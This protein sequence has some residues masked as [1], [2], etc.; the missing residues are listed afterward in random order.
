MIEYAILFTKVDEKIIWYFGIDISEATMDMNGKILL[1]L[2]HIEF[3]KEKRRHEAKTA[4]NNKFYFIC[5]M[6][7]FAFH[8][9]LWNGKGI[10]YFALSW[11]FEMADWAGC[12]LEMNSTT[13]TNRLL[14]L[15]KRKYR[16][17]FH[18]T[19]KRNW[20]QLIK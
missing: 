5:T 13:W 8:F 14:N 16:P 10:K 11:I 19:K 12:N 4:F 3:D 1:I 17:L 20:F 9:R 18:L 6:P 7:A 2:E 15:C